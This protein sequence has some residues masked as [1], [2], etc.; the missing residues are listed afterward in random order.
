[1]TSITSA[2][3][4]PKQNCV[5]TTLETPSNTS[6][7]TIAALTFFF[8][9]VSPTDT[10]SPTAHNNS[11]TDSHGKLPPTTSATLHPLKGV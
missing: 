11:P 9:A 7:T 10:R 4:L 1:M 2:V 8:D 6:P 3:G 5:T